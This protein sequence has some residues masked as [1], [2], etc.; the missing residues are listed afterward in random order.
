MILINRNG[1]IFLN[2]AIRYNG[3]ALDIQNIVL[4]TGS[5]NTVLD[6]DVLSPLGVSPEPSDIPRKIRG[7]GGIEYV[8]TRRLEQLSIGSNVISEF[9]IEIGELNYG[10]GINGILGLN[11]LIASGAIIDLQKMEITFR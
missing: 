8:F 3:I 6:V 10:F 1:L 4:D 9:E 5:S 11:Y 7:V 2:I